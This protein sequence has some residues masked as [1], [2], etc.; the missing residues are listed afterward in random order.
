MKLS[1][2]LSAVCA[3]LSSAGVLL[4]AGQAQADQVKATLNSL[5]PTTSATYSVTLPNPPT[6]KSGSTSA[7]L[8]TFTQDLG[9]G[10]PDLLPG[11]DAQFVSF[12][13]DL[14]DTIGIPSTHIWDVV[15]L[16]DAPDPKAGPMGSSKALDLAKLFGSNLPNGNLLNSAKLLDDTGKAAMQLAV[17]EIVFESA[18][19]YSTATG[20]ALFRTD[21]DFTSDTAVEIRANQYLTNLSGPAMKG[22]VGLTS[23]VVGGTDTTQDFVSQVPIPAAA[24]LFGSAL[25]GTVALGRRKLKKGD[26]TA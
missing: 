19:P 13:I 3:A 20:N 15:A 18:M 23:P 6:P 11:N 24:W 22:L 9:F 7:G 16:K 1:T 25:V 2:K 14:E 17:W 10:G 12:C 21:G 26:A 5:S 4:Y 8:F